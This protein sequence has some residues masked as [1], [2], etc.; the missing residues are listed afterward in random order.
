[1]M[2]GWRKYFED[3]ILERGLDYY[4][5]NVVRIYD[6]SKDHIDAQVAGSR[7]YDV[8]I[9]IK[10]SKI[11]SMYCNCPYFYEYDY[12]KHLAGVLYYIENYLEMLEPADDISELILSSSHE[13]LSS[14]LI[15]E[16]KNSLNLAN[17]FRLFKNKNVDEEYYI[18]KLKTSLNN[19]INILKFL[20]DDIRELI[21]ND[22]FSLIFKSLTIIID[23]IN[24]ELEYGEYPLMVDIIHKIDDVIS[25]IRNGASIDDISD[26]LE[27]AISTSDDYFIIDELTDCMSRNG[28]IERLM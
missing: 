2:D 8:R 11:Q 12:C 25:Q 1:M 23:H 15:E 9:N 22:S 20:D 18:N 13:E 16:T 10:D 26:F 7:I 6:Y 21:D 24:G 27:Y 19:P 14:F 5:S 3:R 28:D 17:K 4:E